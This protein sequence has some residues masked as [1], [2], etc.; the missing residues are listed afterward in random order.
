MDLEQQLRESYVERLGSL[1]LPGGDVAAARRTGARMRARRRLTV[2]AAAL[3]VV[4]VALG[5][6]LVGTGRVSVGPSHD[7][8]HWRELPAPP[9]SPRA[10]A[11]AVWTGHEVVVVGGETEPCPPGADCAILPDDL[12]DG[13]AYDPGTDRWHRIAQAPVSVGP[14]LIVLTVIPRPINSSERV[15]V[16]WCSA[17]LETA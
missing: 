11:Q 13:A 15:K 5:G 9:L 1:D 4:A 3:A 12:R 17:P 10:N 2:G 16:A 6:T 8:G 7:T 14:G